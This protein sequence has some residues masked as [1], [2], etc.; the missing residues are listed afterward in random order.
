MYRWSHGPWDA[1][2]VSCAV[3]YQRRITECHQIDDKKP[4]EENFCDILTKPD[5]VI[6]TCNAIP[7]PS[8][9]F[10]SDWDQCSAT[11][12]GGFQRRTVICKRNIS[13]DDEE[14]L[15]DQLCSQPKPKFHSTC[16]EGP[17]PPNWRSGSWS[18]C[19]PACGRAGWSQRSIECVNPNGID[20]LNDLYCELSPRPSNRKRCHK[21]CPAPRW[22]PSDWQECNAECGQGTKRRKVICRDYKTEISERCSQR[23]KPSE[24]QSCQGAC[25]VSVDLDSDDNT[26]FLV[27]C[28]DI[29][30]VAYCPLVKKFN[31]CERPYF[32]KMC[33]R[34][35]RGLI[36]ETMFAEGG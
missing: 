17:C 28:E 2:S 19:Q 8:E 12:G 7:C 3:G 1:C 36:G 32:R 9:W 23:N 30:K 27:T 34:T 5:D 35:C 31:F 15:I 24:V 22:Y 6:Q 18:P 25:I 20:V 33:C 21:A 4:V 16:N 11:C 14:Q 10:I 13:E 26:S 29:N